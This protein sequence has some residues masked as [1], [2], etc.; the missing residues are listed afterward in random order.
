LR[1]EDISDSSFLL[2]L[3][4]GHDD[5]SMTLPPASF[6]ERWKPLLDTSQEAFLGDDASNADASSQ[7][8]V[9]A[10]SVVLFRR[11]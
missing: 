3:N 9:M 5:A 2:L 11:V 4:P 10:R 6:G 8:Q 1:G 7:R